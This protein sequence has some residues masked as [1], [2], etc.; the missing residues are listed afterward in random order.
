MNAEVLSV[1]E[2]LQFL[3]KDLNAACE[4]ELFNAAKV[5]ALEVAHQCSLLALLKEQ[6]EQERRWSPMPHIRSI[7]GV[8]V[9]PWRDR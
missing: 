4:Q 6:Q 3:R 1:K 5:L 7:A 9:I 8:P 2:N